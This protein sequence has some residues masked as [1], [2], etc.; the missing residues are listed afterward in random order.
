MVCIYCGGQTKVI[1]SRHQR[2]SNQNWRRRECFICKAVFSTDE[3]VNLERSVSVRQPNGALQPFRRDNLF[4][5]IYLSCGHRKNAA[6][7][8]TGLCA[9][10]ITKLL[11]IIKN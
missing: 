3:L 2:R 9:T 1:N 5:S 7:D 10:V 4:I 6:I 11:P 8:A